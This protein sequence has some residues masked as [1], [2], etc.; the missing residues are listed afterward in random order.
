MGSKVLENNN[1]QTQNVS[2]K[3]TTKSD[4]CAAVWGLEC[5]KMHTLKDVNNIYSR[6]TLCC[7]QQLMLD[8]NVQLQS[9]HGYMPTCTKLLPFDWQMFP[10]TNS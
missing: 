8:L 1:T 7:I 4:S 6:C 2:D 9:D 10:L 5:N 3:I